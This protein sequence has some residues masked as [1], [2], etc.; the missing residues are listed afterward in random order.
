MCGTYVLIKCELLFLSVKIA[1]HK[2]LSLLCV[3]DTSLG[4][5]FSVM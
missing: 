2:Q 3:P 4:G 1:Q 5:I